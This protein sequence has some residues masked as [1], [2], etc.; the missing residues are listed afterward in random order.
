MALI[1]IDLH[2]REGITGR[3]YLEPY[4]PKSMQYLIPALNDLAEMFRGRPVVPVDMYAQ[5]RG[6][7]CISSAMKALP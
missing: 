2:T 1:L 6:N 5:R 3:A 4:V 7:P